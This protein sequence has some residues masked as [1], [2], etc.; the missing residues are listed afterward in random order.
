MSF[1]SMLRGAVLLMALD[2]ASG[3]RAQ[4]IEG[5]LVERYHVW[6]SA[7]PGAAPLVTYRIY[8]DL[9][10]GH[11]LLTVFG[12]KGRNLFFRTTTRFFNDTLN[13]GSA[14][15]RIDPERLRQFPLALDSWLALGFA[16]SAHKAVPLH[17][18]EDGSVLGKPDRK[19]AGAG[20]DAALLKRD[21]LAA[22]QRVPEVMNLY[23]STSYLDRL[24]GDLIETSVG[25]YGTMGS[26]AGATE[27]NMV[28]IAQLTTDGELSYAINAAIRAPDGGI[29]KHLA[30]PA[31]ASDEVELPFL[32]SGS[33]F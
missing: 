13:G 8:L 5:V 14:G 27:E 17:L 21:G 28:L 7:S 18:D 31:S 2:S 33:A 3:A 16:T 24:G 26:V 22:A 29:I 20:Y 19:H 4:G 15:E 10:P 25:A 23:I 1:G 30:Y 9:A 32:R 12:E 11:S 6:M